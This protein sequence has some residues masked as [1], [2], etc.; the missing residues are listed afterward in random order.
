MLA[1]RMREG[2][3]LLAGDAAHLTPPFLGQGLCSG[4]RDAANLA[5]KL[6]LVLRGLAPR[7]AARHGRRRAPAA[8]RVGHPVRD[9]ARARSSASSTPRPP[10]SATRS[11]RGAGAAAAARVRAADRR[12]APPGADG[13]PDPLAGRLSVQGRVD[14]STGAKGCFDDVVGRGFALIAAD[15]DPLE[16]LDDE[17]RDALDALDATVASL[18]PT[19]ARRSRDVDGRL[20]DWL[21]EHGAH[22]VLVR[23]DFYVFGSVASRDGAA[24]AGRRP[25]VAAGARTPNPYDQGALTHVRRTV[26]HPK[27]HHFNLKTT[28]L[29]EMIDWYCDRSSAPR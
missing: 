17:Q 2:R 14:A 6:D 15:G 25:A 12:R 24:G 11:L 28:R 4:L 23:P 21:A 7:R 26:I 1:E 5:W 29:Q 10:P 27:F 13:A 8:E 9:R 22:A 16:Q 18:D 20:T 19:R 3:V